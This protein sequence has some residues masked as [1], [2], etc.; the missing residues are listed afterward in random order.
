[1]QPLQPQT[2][3]EAKVPPPTKADQKPKAAEQKKAAQKKAA[4]QAQ[5]APQQLAIL[6][7][8][9]NS[10]A[11][12]T[13]QVKIVVKRHNNY[14]EVGLFD[15]HSGQPAWAFRRHTD[16]PK[17][18]IEWTVP[19][20][21]TI[22]SIEGKT[23]SLP[24]DVDSNQHGG[25]PGKPFKATVRSDPEDPPTKTYDY[26]ITVTYEPTNGDA[27]RLVIDPEMIV[28]NP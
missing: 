8:Q 2:D 13:D 27:V 11:P 28:N 1:M 4:L 21:V 9:I 14:V 5:A 22:E 24:I 10:V 20:D 3:Q 26:A 18:E 25:A 12:D 16:A 6:Q 7:A 15:K 17:N 23:E 19:D